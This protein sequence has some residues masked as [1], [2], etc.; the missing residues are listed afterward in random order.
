[1]HCNNT[2]PGVFWPQYVHYVQD[3]RIYHR[4]I[5]FNDLEATFAKGNLYITTEGF[6]PLAKLG[7]T[8]TKEKKCMHNIC[9]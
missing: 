7:N 4:Y 3:D 5:A 1:M 9:P 8:L 6:G 2:C